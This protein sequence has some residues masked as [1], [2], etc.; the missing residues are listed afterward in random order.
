MV[1]TAIQRPETV[2]L[3]VERRLTRRLDL[4]GEQRAQLHK[5]LVET[6]GQIR[7]L[8]QEVRPRVVLALARANRDIAAI[9]TPEQ[10]VR[11]E[12]WKKEN[13]LFQREARREAPGG[14]GKPE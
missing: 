14:G 7:E 1:A 10:R 4:D 3:A 5:I 12:K 13:A 6:Q 2:E 11:F 9:L 8:R